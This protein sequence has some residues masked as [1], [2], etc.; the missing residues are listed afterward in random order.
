MSQSQR[1]FH[2]RKEASIACNNRPARRDQLRRIQ[3]THLFRYQVLHA[4]KGKK[5]ELDEKQIAKAE[6]LHA[7]LIKQQLLRQPVEN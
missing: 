1:T 6:T 3:H 2:L 7:G 4:F 5:A